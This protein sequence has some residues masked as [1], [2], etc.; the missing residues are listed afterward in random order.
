MCPKGTFVLLSPVQVLKIALIAC[1]RGCLH[2][3]A[4]ADRGS[5]ALTLAD[6]SKQLLGMPPIQ[7]PGAIF[8]GLEKDLFTSPLDVSTISLYPTCQVLHASSVIQGLVHH[9]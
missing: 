2:I 6:L 7:H 5:R 8:N 9:S 4:L 1:I 3:D